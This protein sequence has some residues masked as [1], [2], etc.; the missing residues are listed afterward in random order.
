M[1]KG[2]SEPACLFVHKIDKIDYS[3]FLWFLLRFSCRIDENQEENRSVPY[4]GKWEFRISPVRPYPSLIYRSQ[5]LIVSIYVMTINA[6]WFLFF[7]QYTP[8]FIGDHLS[9]LHCIIWETKALKLILVLWR[10]FIKDFIDYR[11]RSFH[12]FNKV[13]ILLLF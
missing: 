1:F 6:R 2:S 3:F 12:L 9:T 8:V 10:E 5:S 13:S 4:V 7:R 11:L